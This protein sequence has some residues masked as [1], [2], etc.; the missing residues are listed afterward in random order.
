[1]AIEDNNGIL[2]TK[3]GLMTIVGKIKGWLNKKLDIGGDAEV[4]SV[5]IDGNVSMSSSPAT[6]NDSA[7]VV[8][9]STVESDTPVPV[10]IVT[11]YGSVVSDKVST[12]LLVNDNGVVYDLPGGTDIDPVTNE[13]VTSLQNYGG[14]VLT[15]RARSFETTSYTVNGTST[16]TSVVQCM[17]NVYTFVTVNSVYRGILRIGL[18]GYKAFAGRCDEYIID[19]AFNKTIGTQLSVSLEV[20]VGIGYISFKWLNG[21]PNWAAMIGKR[22]QLR[23]IAD[24]VSW[25][26]VS[27]SST[28]SAPVISAAVVG[29]GSIQDARTAIPEDD[30]P[31]MWILEANDGVND[32]VKPIWYISNGVFIDAIGYVIDDTNDTTPG[33]SLT[34]A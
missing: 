1:M 20:P 2:V 17:Q 8:F 26:V 31:F 3:A 18:P 19:L 28:A 5:I 24:T 22:V 21:E 16:S 15:T 23:I 12:R 29:H 33:G 13:D 14:T 7:A 11:T 30:S 25:Y 4:S 6:E 32:I 34:P 9:E 10:D 27:G